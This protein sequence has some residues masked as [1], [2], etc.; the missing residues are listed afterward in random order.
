[1]QWLVR[2]TQA[3][4]T[5]W[6]GLAATPTTTPCYIRTYIHTYLQRCP[7]EKQSVRGDVVLIQDLCQFAV[8]VLHAVTFVNDHVLPLQLGQRSLVLHHILVG[9]EEHVESTT[10]ECVGQV[11]SLVGA[12]LRGVRG[13]VDLVTIHHHFHHTTW[14]SRAVL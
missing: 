12:T 9:G 5:Q 3:N 13:S 8:V 10:L 7:C 11:A 14:I 1:M 2:V 6:E 4:I